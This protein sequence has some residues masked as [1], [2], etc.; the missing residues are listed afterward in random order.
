MRRASPA[1]VPKDFDDAAEVN[2][3]R[4]ADSDLT[5]QN[6]SIF[7]ERNGKKR[8]GKKSDWAFPEIV[9]GRLGYEA[10]DREGSKAREDAPQVEERGAAPETSTN[11][12]GG[13]A[14]RLAVRTP[15]AG[16][17]YSRLALA[18]QNIGQGRQAS[19]LLR[20]FQSIERTRQ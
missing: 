12:Y 16:A 15:A 9:L 18:R 6:L 7:V 13:E 4:L 8:N 1:C 10:R 5:A 20:P 14:T 2:K 17:A 11:L 3:L 19:E